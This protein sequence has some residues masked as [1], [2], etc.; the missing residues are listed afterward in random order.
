MDCGLC[1]S[2]IQ[3]FPRGTAENHEMLMQLRFEPLFL[4]VFNDALH[5]LQ[6]FAVSSFI[7]CTLH[8]ILLLCNGAI[9]AQLSRQRGR[10]ILH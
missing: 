3:K 1:D 6:T 7:I 2:T 9:W 4:R 8:Q 5:S 10:N